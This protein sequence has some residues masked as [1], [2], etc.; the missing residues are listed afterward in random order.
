MYD[1]SIKKVDID[2]LDDIV[3]QWNNIY[4]RIIEMKPLD[5]KKSENIDSGR[6]NN[7]KDPNLIVGDWSCQN[8][9]R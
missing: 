5:V 4:H 2:R 7:D 3:D 1:C 8:V 9:K 6:E